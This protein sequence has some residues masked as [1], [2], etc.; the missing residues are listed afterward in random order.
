M[1]IREALNKLYN[2][3]PDGHCCDEYNGQTQ[4]CYIF[5]ALGFHPVTPGTDQYVFGSP[6][7]DKVTLTFE[8]GK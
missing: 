8:D 4:A 5:S 1:H 6:L 3:T 2:C 7:F